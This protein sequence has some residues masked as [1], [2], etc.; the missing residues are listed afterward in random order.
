MSAAIGLAASHHRYRGWCTPCTARGR[1]TVER[2]S[3]QSNK[4]SKQKKFPPFRGKPAEGAS[5]QRLHVTRVKHN[6]ADTAELP[7][8]R[9]DLRSHGDN[10][11][12]Q[13]FAKRR[14]ARDRVYHPPTRTT[15][16]TVPTQTAAHNPLTTPRPC[17]AADGTVSVWDARSV[18]IVQRLVGHG[19]GV[20]WVSW[21]NNSCYI[22]SASDDKTVRVWSV[23]TVFVLLSASGSDYLP[24]LPFCHLFSFSR[25]GP[26]NTFFLL[27]DKVRFRVV[28]ARL[29]LFWKCP[30]LAAFLSW[31]TCH[32]TSLLFAD[33]LQYDAHRFSDGSPHDP[34]SLTL[35]SHR[36][37]A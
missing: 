5:P 21:T 26:A 34:L 36:E 22:A 2:H 25:C 14:A 24:P 33:V 28:K 19:G 31:R 32:P 9:E 1:C 8:V 15:A 4:T 20:S 30:D 27:A 12:L 16:P 37:N 10:L 6:A 18:S 11:V 13:L 17:T 29:K 23:K 35:N 3:L 7:A